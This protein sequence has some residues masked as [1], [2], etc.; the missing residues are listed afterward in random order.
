VEA[1]RDDGI[2]EDWR[3]VESCLPPEAFGQLDMSGIQRLAPEFRSRVAAGWRPAELRSHLGGSPFP[4]EVR[5]MTGLVLARLKDMPVV[6]PGLRP[7][8]RPARP[9]EAG[10]PVNRAEGKPKPPGWVKQFSGAG[11]AGSGFEDGGVP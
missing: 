5:S 1:D 11:S 8:P 3:L 6:Y 4:A 2:Q 10:V 9:A 7:A